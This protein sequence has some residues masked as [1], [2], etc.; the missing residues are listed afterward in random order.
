MSPG[1]ACPYGNGI[2]AAWYR[3]NSGGP[4]TRVKNARLFA[5]SAPT[6][7]SGERLERNLDRNTDPWSR[8]STERKNVL[9]CRCAS[10][11]VWT[12]TGGMRGSATL[13]SSSSPR[14]KHTW[15]VG[16]TVVQCDVTTSPSR[17]ES[18]GRPRSEER[19]VGKECRSRWSPYH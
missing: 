14:L 1:K 18:S 4:Y 9:S 13:K 2:S 19:R 16:R 10:L 15:P 8:L 3:S 6:S 11:L 17:R 5:T 12:V 7:S